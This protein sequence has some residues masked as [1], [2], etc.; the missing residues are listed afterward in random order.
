MKDDK[1]RHNHQYMAKQMPWLNCNTHGIVQVLIKY[2]LEANMKDM[3]HVPKCR[4][5]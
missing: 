3:D 2:K 1:S 4:E 5:Y